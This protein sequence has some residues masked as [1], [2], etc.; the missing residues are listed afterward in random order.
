[1]NAAWTCPACRKAVSTN[2]C[3]DCGEQPAHARQLALRELLLQALHAFTSM[4]G[5]LMRSWRQLVLRPGA[6]TAAYLEGQRK[7]WILPLQLFLITNVVFFAAQ[8]VTGVKVF[9][10]TLAMHL[11]VQPWSGLAQ[12]LVAR[13]LA[14]MGRTL[15]AYAPLFDHAVAINA[16]SLIVLMVVPFA[17]LPALLWKRQR[18]TFAAHVAFSLHVYS[19]LLLLFCASSLVIAISGWCGGPGRDSEGLDHAVTI[20]ELV[21]GGIHL[22]L[23][24]GRAYGARGFARVPQALALTVSVA[25]IALGYRFAVFA[26]TLYT[27]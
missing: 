17:L 23:A 25:A 1:M 20:A 9:S 2:F 27:T 8:T 10:T 22:L 24:I 13:R 5:K 3:P 18:R 26:I 4:D 6:L 14:A 21:A 11:H 15:E 12:R 7:A 19:F 16:R